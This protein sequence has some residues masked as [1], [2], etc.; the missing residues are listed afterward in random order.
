MNKLGKFREYSRS[1]A[2]TSIIVN[3]TVFDQSLPIIFKFFHRIFEIFRFIR[4][5]CVHRDVKNLGSLEST[6]EAMRIR[7]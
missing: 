7:V 3:I 1:Y 6:Q 2:Y 4:Q 5:L